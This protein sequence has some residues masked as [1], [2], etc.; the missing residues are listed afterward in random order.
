M[1]R[2]SKRIKDSLYYCFVRFTTSTMTSLELAH[3]LKTNGLSDAQCI[4]YDKKTLFCIAD[5]ETIEDFE[6]NIKE[7]VYSFTP[8]ITSIYVSKMRKT[9]SSLL[10]NL[11]KVFE[12]GL[13]MLN[14]EESHQKY[15]SKSNFNN[16]HIVDASCYKEKA[17]TLDI[18]LKGQFIV[19]SLS[20]DVDYIPQF[21]FS[22]VIYSAMKQ[23]MYAH[24][25]VQS[26]ANITMY[27]AGKKEHFFLVTL[28]ECIFKYLSTAKNRANL[29]M[30]NLYYS[31]D[32]LIVAKYIGTLTFYSLNKGYERIDNLTEEE[33]FNSLDE[34]QVSTTISLYVYFTILA[35]D[36]FTHNDY[37]KLFIESWLHYFD[38]DQWTSQ[39]IIS[40]KGGK[41]WRKTFEGAL[42]SD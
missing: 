13:N 23:N 7:I 8:D 38:F 20:N 40:Q 1:D 34:N 30:K 11:D 21:K 6:N 37:N 15:V 26:K 2:S 14:V 39:L 31:E 10:D 17:N 19:E 29:W 9:S 4:E 18:K 32:I 28:K 16:N 25:C 3:L 42:F 22:D 27:N 36:Y 5:L 24:Y 33:L 35:N 12:Q 41:H